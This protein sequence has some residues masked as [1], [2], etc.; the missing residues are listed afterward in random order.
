MA[1]AEYLIAEN[2]TNP[3]KLAIFG[4][5]NGGLL[6]GAISI[7]IPLP[8]DKLAKVSSRSVTSRSSSVIRMTVVGEYSLPVK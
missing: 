8:L 1:A 2:Y 5:S 4:G 3:S 7:E 6:I